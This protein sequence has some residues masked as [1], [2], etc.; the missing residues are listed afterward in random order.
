MEI[1]RKINAIWME[2]EWNKRTDNERS[3]LGTRPPEAWTDHSQSVLYFYS[4]FIQFPFIYI[5]I[6]IQLNEKLIE[7]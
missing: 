3:V 6:S 7:I 5:E 1:E 2:I 4:I